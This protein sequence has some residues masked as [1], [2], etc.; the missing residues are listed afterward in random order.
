MLIK[1][2][3]LFCGSDDRRNEVTLNRSSS[4]ETGNT[5]AQLLCNMYL[6]YHID[7]EAERFGNLFH[8]SSMSEGNKP[9]IEK[10]LDGID[11]G[12]GNEFLRNQ[13]EIETKRQL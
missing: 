3:N 11:S 7:D 6:V 2:H 10:V 8:N 5:H 9:G 4:I 1:N 12:L 13:R